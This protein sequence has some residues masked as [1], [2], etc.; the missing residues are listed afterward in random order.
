MA[1]LNDEEIQKVKVIPS[2]T[3]F[4]AFLF[5]LNFLKNVS[6]YFSTSKGF[7]K[8][9]FWP[10]C[11]QFFVSTRRSVENLTCIYFYRAGLGAVAVSDST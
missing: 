8:A 10:I 3:E 1:V 2:N 7:H 4:S 5:K 9:N 11:F 6:S